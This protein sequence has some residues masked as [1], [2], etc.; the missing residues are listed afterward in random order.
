MANLSKSPYWR[1][2]KTEASSK[3]CAAVF[4]LPSMYDYDFMR[5]VITQLRSSLRSV[6]WFYDIE[7]VRLARS[8]S[9]SRCWLFCHVLPCFA[10]FCHVLQCFAMF[11]H[12][13]PC[14]AMFC[15]VLPCFAM[16]CHVLPCFACLKPCHISHLVQHLVTPFQRISGR[17]SNG[18]QR[19][20]SAGPQDD[21][22]KAR[23]F[24]SYPVYKTVEVVLRRWSKLTLFLHLQS[25][26]MYFPLP[27]S[28]AIS[29]S[30][31]QQ[32]MRSKC[33]KPQQAHAKSLPAYLWC[34]H[35]IAWD[36]Q[37]GAINVDPALPVAE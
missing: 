21:K 7:M 27:K 25:W 8:P 26:S 1:A 15:H 18:T 37:R 5:L 6:F 34:T 24:Y 28:A 2:V 36:S 22:N 30:M 32:S 9:A 13:L 12:V 29:F 31:L 11:C 20:Q 23:P 14:F 17:W 35:C 16:F 33:R 4:A 10:M 3:V 19:V